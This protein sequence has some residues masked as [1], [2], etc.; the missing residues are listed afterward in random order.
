M[1]HTFQK[2]L[3][4]VF[5]A[6]LGWLSFCG[7][8][9]AAKWLAREY[10]VIDILAVEG[11]V[12]A[13]L[14]G[15]WVLSDKKARVLK[16]PKL[17]LHLLRAVTV[18]GVAGFSVSAI[19]L[20]PLADLYSIGFLQPSLTCLLAF[21]IFGEKFGWPRA[22]AIAVG[23]GGVLI[24]AGPRFETL[25]V[26][27]LYAFLAALFLSANI[28]IVRRIGDK[29]P[30]A[31]Y[32]FFPF[33]A[34]LLCFGPIANWDTIL[35]SPQDLPL[36]VLFALLVM[37]GQVLT[38]LGHARAPEATLIAPFHYTQM[39][40]GLAFGYLIFA[41]VP[42]STTLLGASLIIGSGL[43]IIWQAKCRNSLAMQ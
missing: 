2:S 31:L 27:L 13:A 34:I 38:S 6:C 19:S 20:I 43:F 17:K 18:V 28:F 39:I 5:L 12:G 40:W 29:E 26:G 30:L 25:N 14:A 10:S 1:S 36:F 16:T 7:C 37:G 23:F 3:Q 24:L 35:S 11:S 22:L 42:P 15:L 9:A 41:E 32:S 21:F 4:A 33:C 8:D